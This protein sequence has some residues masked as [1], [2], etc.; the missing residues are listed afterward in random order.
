MIKVLTEDTIKQEIQRGIV[1]VDCYA[2][3]CNPC[4]MLEP[5]MEDL[6][7]STTK[8]TIYKIN[9]EDTPD[10]SGEYGIISIPIVLFFKEGQLIKSSNGVKPKEEYIRIIEE[11]L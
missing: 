9:V 5:V 3:W 8:A 1:A 4:K 10:F 6:A 2:P 7:A 11:M